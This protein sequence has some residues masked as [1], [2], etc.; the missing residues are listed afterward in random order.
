MARPNVKEYHQRIE[1][2]IKKQKK[3]RQAEAAKE[4]QNEA[5]GDYSHLKNKKGELI[6]TPLPQPTLPQLSVDDD[7]TSSVMTR[8]PPPSTYTQ[9]Y[10]YPNDKGP[11]P[12]PAYN[13]YSNQQPP[14]N[15]AHFNP[16]SGTIHADDRSTYGPYSHGY[17]DDT[18]STA[19]LTA[20]A[21]PFARDPIDRRG[22]PFGQQPG[23]Q[24]GYGG[25]QQTGPP[26]QG[27]WQQQQ[28]QQHPN[29]PRLL[30]T[31]SS[32]L[33]YDDLVSDYYANNPQDQRQPGYSQPPQG[34]GRGQGGYP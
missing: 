33:G 23:S 14:G 12:M 15:F 31:R 20:A 24:P 34:P 1:E 3:K 17:D 9:D 26:P 5:R 28:H 27:H 10:Y 22:S 16:S 11:P 25:Y 18:E 6:A 13:P 2:I 8:G 21:A 32:T 7:E 29:Q 19:H 30:E 4:A